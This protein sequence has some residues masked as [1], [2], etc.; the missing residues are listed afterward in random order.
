MVHQV[1]YHTYFMDGVDKSKLSK[2]FV[3]SFV[4]SKNN[5][6]YSNMV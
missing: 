6:L 3:F 5:Y 2:N 4:N 1:D